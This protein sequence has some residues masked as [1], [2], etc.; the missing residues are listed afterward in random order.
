MG[1][2]DR[3]AP[4]RRRPRAA[5]FIDGEPVG[6]DPSRVLLVDDEAVVRT[7]FESLLPP[8]EFVVSAYGDAE[9]A[10]AAHVPGE[11]E[12]AI[13]DK[14]LPGKN[15][16]ELMREL[17]VRDPL[18][19]VMLITGYASL[20][21]AI[22]ALQLG[23]YDY[24]EKPFADIDIVVEK[25]RKAI[26]RRTLTVTNQR[27]LASLQHANQRLTER[28]VELLEAQDELMRQLRLASVGQLAALVGTEL[29]EP[30][31]GIKSNTYVLQEALRPAVELTTRLGEA[32][33]QAANG[34]SE[35]AL[36]ALRELG[37]S[38]AIA[39]ASEAA[40][41]A[42]QTLTEM[43]EEIGRL[44][45]MIKAMQLFSSQS[46]VEPRSVDVRVCVE[47]A[48]ELSDRQRRRRGVELRLDIPAEVPMVR[49]TPLLV[50]QAC[51]N[52][53]QN[54]LEA[55]PAEGLV[56]VR[57]R[58]EESRVVVSISD[59]GGGMT[60]AELARIM[61]P[62]YT[63]KEAERHMGLGLNLAQEIVRRHGGTLRIESDQGTGTRV[64]LSFPLA[65]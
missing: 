58:H 42:M 43:K 7:L 40:S 25:A 30:V 50:T 51:L 65:S 46:R 49:A 63:T 20:P 11:F 8:P 15:G 54:A 12:L 36:A 56:E 34:E 29:S 16:L 14:N 23:A 27:L 55:I 64:V 47:R 61:R 44:V 5:G 38:G 21:T 39:S 2:S 33:R 62:F 32:A 53:L 28:N 60:K 4:A 59:T 37:E 57:V 31:A 24:L 3:R 35:P 1:G 10:L 9:S 52:V 26:E 13:L 41:D 6:D 17:K 48:I 18:L 19:E 22:E 45:A